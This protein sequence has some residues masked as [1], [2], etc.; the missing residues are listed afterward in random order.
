MAL[1]GHPNALGRCPL[2][3]VKRTS[4]ELGEMSAY[5]PYRKSTS[6]YWCVSNGPI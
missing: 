6:G 4:I 2:L 3:G 1:N 5:D